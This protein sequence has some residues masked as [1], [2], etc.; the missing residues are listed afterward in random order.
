MPNH[1][2]RKCKAFLK[3]PLPLSEWTF[4]L[5]APSPQ[6]RAPRR[7]VGRGRADR[8]LPL[9]RRPARVP[10]LGAAQDVQGDFVIELREKNHNVSCQYFWFQAYAFLGMLF[11]VVIQANMVVLTLHFID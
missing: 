1:Q 5:D 8:R 10:H 7:L 4:Y 11:Q 3:P 6:A 2:V 9:L